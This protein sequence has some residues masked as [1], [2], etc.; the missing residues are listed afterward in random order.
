MQP[1]RQ[2]A[3]VEVEV[4]PQPEQHALGVVGVG[5]SRVADGSEEDGVGC[6]E[7]FPYVIRDGDAGAHIR[8][9]VD[10]EFL[11]LEVGAGRAQNF[12]RLWHDL[13]PRPIA[14][15]DGNLFRHGRWWLP[16]RAACNAGSCPSRSWAA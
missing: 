10:V 3:G 5:N 16:S 14:G 7:L 12:D 11:E 8:I 9:R 2:E 6:C 15:Q 1:R 13:L 4:E